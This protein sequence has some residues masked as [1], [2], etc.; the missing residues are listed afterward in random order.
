M[1]I[2]VGRQTENRIIEFAVGDWRIEVAAED[3]QPLLRE[4]EKIGESEVLLQAPA[5]A[6]RIRAALSSSSGSGSHGLVELTHSEAVATLRAIEHARFQHSPLAV[7]LLRLRDAL[8]RDLGLAGVGFSYAL[9]SGDGTT[10][11]ED[12]RSFSGPYSMGDRLVTKDGCEWR[13][14]EVQGEGSNQPERLVVEPW[15]ET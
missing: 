13:V 10:C 15:V 12:F 11:E 5:P 1:T 14:R 9:M 4:L 2:Q 8:Q 7:D 3:F 6:A